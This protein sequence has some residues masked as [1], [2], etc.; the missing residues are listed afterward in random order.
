MDLEGIMLDKLRKTQ[1]EK[2]CT[3]SFHLYVKF[4]IV[5]LIEAES[6]M[7]L[8]RDGE[9]GSKFHL[10]KMEKFWRALYIQYAD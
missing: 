8:S 3:I 6:W 9:E 4:K 5:K 2:Y 10:H 7:V 1:K